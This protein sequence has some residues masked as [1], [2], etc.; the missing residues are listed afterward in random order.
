MAEI[1]IRNV[2]KS[3]ET[4]NG[5]YKALDTVNF[6]IEKNGYSMIGNDINE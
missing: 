6:E 2:T 3:Y 1:E 5:L 4:K